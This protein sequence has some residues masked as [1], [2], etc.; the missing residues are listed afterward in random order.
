M[1]MP[2]PSRSRH[3]AL[4]L[5]GG[6]ELCRVATT[7][8]VIGGLS[9]VGLVQAIDD[10]GVGKVAIGIFPH[11]DANVVGVL[12]ILSKSFAPIDALV[13]ASNRDAGGDGV[14]IQTV[15]QPFVESQVVV[16]PDGL[17]FQFDLDLFCHVERGILGIETEVVVIRF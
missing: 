6:N 17:I 2:I 7:Q 11:I 3:K 9:K 8:T 13:L 1:G 15:I 12:I 14:A 10:Q 5:P 16:H 4:R